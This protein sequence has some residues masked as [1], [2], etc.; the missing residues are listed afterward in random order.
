MQWPPKRTDGF[1]QRKT[2]SEGSSI[3]YVRKIFRK[4]NISY[5]LI[6]TRTRVGGKE[7]LVFQKILLTYLMDGPL[8]VISTVLQTSCKVRSFFT[9]VAD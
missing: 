1:L 4:S 6:Q 2:K 5:P 9:N 3:K 7:M 8:M